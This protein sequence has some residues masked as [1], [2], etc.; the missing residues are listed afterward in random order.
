MMVLREISVECPAKIAMMALPAR[1]Q[2][3][4]YCKNR[5]THG[6]FFL[7]AASCESVNRKIGNSL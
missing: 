1:P 2:R 3:W 4:V 6:A 5:V 7:A